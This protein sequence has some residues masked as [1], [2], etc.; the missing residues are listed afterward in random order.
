MNKYFG[1]TSVILCGLLGGTQLH[2]YRKECRDLNP[3][4]RYAEPFAGGRIDYTLRI[5]KEEINGEYPRECYVQLTTK[6]RNYIQKKLG[7]Y[8]SNK[9]LT[10]KFIEKASRGKM[11]EASALKDV[12]DDFQ[13]HV[14]RAKVGDVLNALKR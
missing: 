1:I 4:I 11:P 9:R 8:S 12:L 6:Q 7:G 10:D 2:G 5:P 14:S 13:E 3:A